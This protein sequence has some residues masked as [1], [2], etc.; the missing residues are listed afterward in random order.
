MHPSQ[1]IGGGEKTPVTRESAKKK[2]VPRWESAEAFAKASEEALGEKYSPESIAGFV[3]YWTEPSANGSM[4]WQ[5]EKYFDISRRMANSARMGFCEP[6]FV[7]PTWNEVHAYATAKNMP[8]P[9]AAS[10]YA[11]YKS[12]GWKAGK[13]RIVDWKPRLSAWCN[14]QQRRE[15]V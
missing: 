15:A 1:S 6:A 14:D 7:P 2:A 13:A 11:H 3:A 10:F 12:V 5:G 8:E 9:W 4:R